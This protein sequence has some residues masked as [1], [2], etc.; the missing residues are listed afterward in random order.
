[1]VENKYHFLPYILRKSNYLDPIPYRIL[2][3]LCTFSPCYP[4]L[5]KI[6]EETGI[7][8]RTIRRQLPVLEEKGFLEIIKSK[9]QSNH[10]AKFNP[11]PDKL[12]KWAKENIPAIYKTWK[13]SEEK[14]KKQRDGP[15]HSD[16]TQ[17]QQ[18][19]GPWTQSPGCVDTKSRVPWTQSPPNIN[20]NIKNNKKGSASPLDEGPP[21]VKVREG[22]ADMKKISEVIGELF[23]LLH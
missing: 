11:C 3:C 7:N 14:K 16:R 4:S 6:S 20:K 2:D 9:G 13:K 10:Y 18:K 21:L 1:M 5:A 23:P 17:G 22:C 15:G 19:K 8:E 12:I